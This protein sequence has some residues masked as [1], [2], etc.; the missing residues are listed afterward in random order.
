MDPPPPFFI[1]HGT[2]DS[3]IP[4]E[5]ARRFYQQ[6]CELRA[7]QRDTK[8]CVDDVLVEI[9]EAVHGFNMV[10]SPLS[11]ALFDSIA[12]FLD[13]IERG[14]MCDEGTRKLQANM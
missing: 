7:R 6:L 12:I 2:Y 5:D 9:P 8:T 11:F 3:L 10:H 4:I 13:K 14:P 1:V